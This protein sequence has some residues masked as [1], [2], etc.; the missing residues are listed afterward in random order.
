MRKLDRRRWGA[1]VAVD[2][3]GR[4]VGI[5]VTDASALDE[6]L[7]YLPV[8]LHAVDAAEVDRLYSIVVGSRPDQHGRRFHLLYRGAARLTRTTSF[9]ALLAAFE[10]DAQLYVAKHSTD[11]L[12]VHAGVVGWRG[13]AI[14]L[15]GRSLSAKSSLVSALVRAGATYYSDQYALFDS[16]GR[17]HPFPR[18]LSVPTMSGPE[19]RLAVDEL[20]V[21][22]GVEPLSVGLVAATSHR[23]G[24]RWHVR[25][26][27]LGQIALALLSNAITAP[28][29]ASEALAL[30]GEASFWA[31]GV[32]GTRGEAS[33]SA[34]EILERVCDW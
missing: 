26:L 18:R 21:V 33:E 11:L 5:R 8:G 1:E 13:R 24:G 22:C 6:V 31:I 15:P 20:G 16:S 17:V 23:K 2:G 25:R 30:L 32:R 12:F 14:V 19:R 29:R 9:P 3:Y 10:N 4:T 7:A 28:G 27:D 34:Q